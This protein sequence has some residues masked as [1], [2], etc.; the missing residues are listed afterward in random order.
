MERSFLA[1][2]KQKLDESASTPPSQLGEL[3]VLSFRDEIL[4]KVN[5]YQVTVI[6][7]ATG[8]SKVGNI[9][10]LSCI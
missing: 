8:S 2:L 5:K 1:K 4:E 9:S 10:V 3:Q 7:A 6:S